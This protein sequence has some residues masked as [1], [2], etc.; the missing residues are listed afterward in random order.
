MIHKI[1]L[2]K[3]RIYICVY[4]HTERTECIKKKNQIAF[5]ILK[6]ILKYSLFMKIKLIFSQIYKINHI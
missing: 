1:L 2:N 3:Y 6:F 4:L 5:K